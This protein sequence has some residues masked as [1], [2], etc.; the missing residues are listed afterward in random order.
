MKVALIYLS[1]YKD[2]PMGGMLNY[3]RNIIPGLCNLNGVDVDIWGGTNGNEKQC[4]FQIDETEYSFNR[5]TSF[6]TKGKILPNFV[7]S[8][9]G[10]LLNARKFKKYDVIYSHTAATT[11]SLKLMNPRKRVVHHQHGLS[12]KGTKGI[13]RILNIGYFLAQLLADATL[14]VASESEVQQHKNSFIGFKNKNFYSIGS[15]INFKRIHEASL[16][17]T[18]NEILQFVYCGR[19]DEWKNIELLVNAFDMFLD[20]GYAGQLTLVGDG[21]QFEYI[22]EMIRKLKREKEI[23]AIGRKNEKEIAQILGQSDIFLFPTKGEGVSLALLEAFSAGLP[24]LT[25][26][27]IGVNN[28]VK[29]NLTGIV[30]SELDVSHYKEGIIK[31]GREYKNYKNNCV[32]VARVYD[33]DNIVQKISDVIVD[34]CK[35]S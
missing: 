14:F 15:P 35:E 18:E 16:E 1:N 30:V 17:K 25:F 26:D 13:V 9:F 20:E 12:Y 2:W 27:V 6:Y 21:P 28:F 33:K 3:V 34:N 10:A 5:Y 8:F 24:A 19:I 4:T 23:A 32:E 11:I 22:K 31:L 29:N 7:I